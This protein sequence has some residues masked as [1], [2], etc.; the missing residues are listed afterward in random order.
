[1][2]ILT[3]LVSLLIGPIIIRTYCEM[4]IVVFKIQGV[5]IEIRDSDRREIEKEREAVL[6]ANI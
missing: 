3:G 2:Q 5:L 6:S 4:L 1:M